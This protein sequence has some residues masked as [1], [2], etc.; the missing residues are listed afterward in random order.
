[1]KNTQ[2][3]PTAN[4]LLH[5][6]RCQYQRPVRFLNINSLGVH[7]SIKDTLCKAGGDNNMVGFREVIVDQTR[8]A[9]D[10]LVISKQSEFTWELGAQMNA[11]VMDPTSHDVENRIQ[12]KPS[13]V[14][15]YIR[16]FIHTHR[17][18]LRACTAAQRISK[19]IKQQS[20]A[21]S[22]HLITLIISKG[23]YY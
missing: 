11:S 16:L 3:H 20:L 19:R 1:M 23:F 5:L 8:R 14:H 15:F 18:Q 4:V 9:A 6:I 13:H 17:H 21:L 10:Y 22:D 7:G 12:F 2:A